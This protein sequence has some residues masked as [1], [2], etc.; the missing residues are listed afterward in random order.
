MKLKTKKLRNLTIQ[1]KDQFQN[2]FK[3]ILKEYMNLYNK[4]HRINNIKNN[5]SI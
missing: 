3:R 4:S 1:M 2:K 5:L